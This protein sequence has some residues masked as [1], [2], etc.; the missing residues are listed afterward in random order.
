M[1]YAE[2]DNVQVTLDFMQ[3]RVSEGEGLPVLHLRPVSLF[4][5]SVNLLLHFLFKI[6]KKKNSI[7]LLVNQ[8]DKSKR[9]SAGLGPTLDFGVFDQHAERV[10][11]G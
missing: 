6:K 3:D 9:P 8:R 10:S 2:G 4:D 5:Y 1:R 7:Y 11:D